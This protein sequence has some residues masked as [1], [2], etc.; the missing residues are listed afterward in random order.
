[1]RLRKLEIKDM[2]PFGHAKIDLSK[3]DLA[4]IVGDNDEEGKDSNGSG[5]SFIFDL[6]AYALFG[7]IMRKIPV[8]KHVRYGTTQGKVILSFEL[9]GTLY[10]IRRYR[11]ANN[12]LEFHSKHNGEM[13]DLTSKT[14]TQTQGIIE[15]V[16]GM[17]FDTFRAVT[18]FGQKDI[19]V[20]ADGT[21]KERLAIIGK[22][23]R[24]E[25]LDGAAKIARDRL[26]EVEGSV[27]RIQSLRDRV[28]AELDK[29]D[30]DACRIEIKNADAN[31][32][33][34]D[35]QLRSTEAK[36]EKL[37]KLN[38]LISEIEEISEEH[39]TLKREWGR[40]R[41]KLGDR[42][43]ELNTC[44]EGLPALVQ[45]IV[46]LTETIKPLDSMK[47]DKEELEGKVSTASQRF[48][49]AKGRR[50][51]LESER[52]TILK[53]LDLEG[54]A[55]PTCGRKVDKVAAQAVRARAEEIDAE[56]VTYSDKMKTIR[57]RMSEGAKAV[58]ALKQEIDKLEIK[59][60]SLTRLKIE[61]ESAKGADGQ[62]AQIKG[63]IEER[64]KVYRDKS[65]KLTKRKKE[66]RVEIK[67]WG[68]SEGMSVR[69]YV[70]SEGTALKTEREKI[71]AEIRLLTETRAT[72]VERLGQV[73][74][75][76]EEL[77]LYDDQLAELSTT[78]RTNAYWSEG[79]PRIKLLIVDSFIPE[80]EH[81][82]NGYLAKM[83]PQVQVRFETLVPK[84]GRDAGY[85][86]KFEIFIRDIHTGR[87]SPWDAW[88]GG[89][90]KR[91]ALA[92]YLGLNAVAS[93]AIE[94]KIGFLLLD[95]VLADLDQT[96]RELTLD[97]LEEERRGQRT[98][99]LISH[100][101]GIQNKFEDV[102][103][104]VKRG[105]IATVRS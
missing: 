72:Y 37:S 58:L 93:T 15:E 86:E 102:I 25:I 54:S 13:K 43:K 41:D 83:A 88:S 100:L 7:R 61:R 82:V 55:C 59:K 44:A 87:E 36:R 74:N 99:F 69:A 29:I 70:N 40:E 5:K 22:L 21:S 79:F 11:G 34:L 73:S 28:E 18:Y 85:M 30:P 45:K 68:I 17:D 8:E 6:I 19:S 33:M 104:V 98:I 14:P 38:T 3:F 52:E 35:G 92:L 81:A 1:M 48:S 23:L 47:A 26:R 12:A 16:I 39:N 24:L 103:T 84:K 46:A 96:G 49:T 95:E 90:K 50:D 71:D 27:S 80:F 20:F 63:D 94:S 9:D 4:L 101:P 66:I 10:R 2:F 89:E 51:A 75:L 42:I 32:E 57:G 105:G 31:L 76:S 56:A 78:F 91:V 67:T 64:G 60:N 62:I 65:E 97:L 53:V 77:E